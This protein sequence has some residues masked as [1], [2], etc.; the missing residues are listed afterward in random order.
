[1]ADERDI[2]KQPGAGAQAPAPEAPATAVEEA[3]PEVDAPDGAAAERDAETDLAELTAQRDE[4]LALAQR[5]Q[6][7]FENYRKRMA[8]EVRAAEARGT[9]KLARELLPALDTLHLALER[10]GPEADGPLGEGV[11]LVLG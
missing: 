3:E 8:K 2:T 4:Y 10:S 7:D 11:R 5:T 1:M 9:G 6:A